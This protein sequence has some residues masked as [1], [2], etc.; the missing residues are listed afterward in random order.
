MTVGKQTD[1]SGCEP[2]APCHRRAHH[3]SLTQSDRAPHWHDK[4]DQPSGDLRNV[5]ERQKPRPLM[6]HARS[7]SRGESS[8]RNHFASV[9]SHR[10]E[11][12]KLCWPT[13]FIKIALSFDRLASLDSGGCQI[14]L[15]CNFRIEFRSKTTSAFTPVLP[16]TGSLTFRGSSFLYF[17][18]WTFIRKANPLIQSIWTS[19][20]K[21]KVSFYLSQHHIQPIWMREE[22]LVL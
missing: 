14:G 10:V 9:G 8:A 2:T 6:R 19:L 11:S 20:A 7:W 21:V 5:W 16:L 13:S 18:H 15:Q 1:P 12:P 3:R 4:V 17:C 22:N